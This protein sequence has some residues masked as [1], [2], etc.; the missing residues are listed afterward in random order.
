MTSAAKSKPV[1]AFEVV[2]NGRMV[3]T[4]ALS[5]SEFVGEHAGSG[6]KVATAVNG[7]FV[8]EKLRAEKHLKAGDKVEI[9]SPRQGG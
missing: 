7:E 5:L 9:V 4:Q 8:P 3:M 2:V 6:S 1:A